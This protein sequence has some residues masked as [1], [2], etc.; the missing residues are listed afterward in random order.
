MPIVDCH[1]HLNRYT[2]D[3]PATLA[4]RC[5]LL[6]AQMDAN[7]IERALVLS[8]YAVNDD[9]P[10]AGEILDH[11]DGDP[12]IGVVAGV[13]HADLDHR[14]LDE[15][16][17]LLVARRIR[18]LKL[19]PGYEACH[20]ND[21]CFR[22]VYELAAEHGV[23][24]MIHTGDTFSPRGKVR[25]TNP[26]E[27]DDLAVD[28]REVTFVICHLGNPWFTDAMEVIY[29]N[30]NV[31]GDVSGLTLGEFEPRF[32]RFMLAR[33]ND[34][35]AYVNDPGKL[36]FGTDW[37]ISDVASYLRFVRRLE[38]TKE[39]TEGILWRNASRIFGLGM[40]RGDGAE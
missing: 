13:R 34:V 30:E 39:E 4:E 29:K 31:L 9:R 3:Q 2:P 26:L 40:E 18:G 14:Q 10:G 37:P 11:L 5:A 27:V 7:G 6:R 28:F 21:P 19:Y 15:L 32:E 36:M 20:V 8:S 16:R 35:I 25:Y 22:P 1:T 12:R 38:L 23:P 24:V 33:L 17:T